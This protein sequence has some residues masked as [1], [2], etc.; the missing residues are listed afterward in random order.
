MSRHARITAALQAAFSPKSL[1][2]I[3]D[4]AKHHGHAGASPAGETHYTLHITAEAFKG[5]SRVQAHQAIYSVL[6]SEFKSGLHAL[7]IHATT[8]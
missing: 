8:E 1:K 5:M 4:S 7:A 2:L 6:D 3:D